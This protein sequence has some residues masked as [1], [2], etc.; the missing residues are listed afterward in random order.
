MTTP[1]SLVIFIP[2]FKFDKY[3]QSL[4]I[5]FEIHDRIDI[6]LA[7]KFKS[8][9]IAVLFNMFPIKRGDPQLKKYFCKT[10]IP[11]TIN[12]SLEIH[13]IQNNL[14][15]ILDFYFL[16]LELYSSNMAVNYLKI[17]NYYYDK[18]KQLFKFLVSILEKK[19]NENQKLIDL[20]RVKYDELPIIYFNILYYR[21]LS[22]EK[23][24]DLKKKHSITKEIYTSE[25][26]ELYID[27]QGSI[28][29]YINKKN[30]IRSG[31]NSKI[32]STRIFLFR[33][34]TWIT[35]RKPNEY[36]NLLD[37]FGEFFN[38]MITNT[39]LCSLFETLNKQRNY[40]L[41]I[42]KI[43]NDRGIE[44]SEGKLID[45]L[46][47]HMATLQSSNR[48]YKEEEDKYTHNLSNLLNGSLNQFN[49]RSNT[50]ELTG[51]TQKIDTKHPNLG[52]IGEADLI[53]YNERNEICHI[54][55]TLILK[56]IDKKYTEEHLKKIFD[57]DANGLRINFMIIYSKVSHF[58]ILWEKYGEL[59]KSYNFKYKLLRNEFTD[60][61]DNYSPFASIKV[62]LTSHSRNNR[63]CK[64]YHFFLDFY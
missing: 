4:D 7:K 32:L 21:L 6:D 9:E 43:N 36:I 12:L 29:L 19:A 23:I 31:S 27:L 11:N 28:S 17:I 47:K 18:K 60:L 2:L 40:N 49:Y 10:L 13:H 16:R 3:N 8:Y 39:R 22:K 53:I 55:E 46:V 37:E 51:K 59:V 30:T 1:N 26:F 14:F 38:Y 20:L 24:L 50:K 25:V 34:I 48:T 44:L 56:S 33:I 62:G 64:L 63:M 5:R 58:D 42:K 45:I 54:G 57:Y 61:S 15:S 41:K 52:G 35:Q